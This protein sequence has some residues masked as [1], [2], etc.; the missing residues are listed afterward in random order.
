M[1]G[2]KKEIL[3]FV[4]TEMDLEGIR[5]SEIS[6]NRLRQILHGIT[7]MWNFFLSQTPRNR[8]QKSDCQGKGGG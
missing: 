8:E 5:L 3:S 6:S 1:P 4:T 7:Y 2:R